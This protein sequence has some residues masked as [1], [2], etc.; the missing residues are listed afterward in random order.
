MIR[1]SIYLNN[2]DWYITI[3]Y[4][5]DISNADIILSD[6]IRIG[7]DSLDLLNAECLLSNGELNKGITYTNFNNK[8]T[9]TVI[10]RTTNAAEFQNTF[11]HEKRH[12]ARHIKKYYNIDGDSE[13]YAYLNGEIGM[14]AF[15]VAKA[16]MCDNCRHDIKNSI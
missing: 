8:E 3:Y 6:L 16:F 5:S 13:E 1:Q 9:I 14:R 4:E 2:Y 10:S 7:C 15:S 12:I 11:D